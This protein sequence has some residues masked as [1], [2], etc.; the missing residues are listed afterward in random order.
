MKI[1]PLTILAIIGLIVAGVSFYSQKQNSTKPATVATQQITPSP[2]PETTPNRELKTNERFV[3]TVGLYITV[4]EGMTFRE[5]K[6]DDPSR[7]M[8]GGFYIEKGPENEPSYQF[9]VLYNASNNTTEGLEKAKKEMDPA[10]I[11][12]VTLGGYKGIEGLVIGPKNRYLTYIIKD[13]N[14]ISFSTIPP[15]P[16]NKEI[17]DQVLSTISFQ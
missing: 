5:E 8:I 11:K 17:T 10:T 14:L 3:G 9:Y 12:E 6:A 2:T 16:E 4:P 7:P 1:R 13:G 15:S